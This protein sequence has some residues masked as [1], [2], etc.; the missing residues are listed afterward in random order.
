MIRYA[1]KM[2]YDG[3]DY[4]GWQ[5]QKTSDNTIQEKI[6]TAISTAIN[7]KTEIIGCGRTDS[8][9][10]S[11][12][13]VFHFDA[14]DEIDTGLLAYKLNKMLGSQM[15]ILG[16]YKMNKDFHARFDATS[17]SYIY[18][19]KKGKD[20]FDNRFA[21]E[22]MYNDDFNLKILNEAAA[23]LR[24]YDDFFTFCKT[25]TDVKTTLCKISECNWTWN[26]KTN[27]L[28]FHITADRFLR[29][30]IRL[31]VGAC[32]NVNRGKLTLSDLKKALDNKERLTMDWSV[33]AQGLMLHK[34]FYPQ[35]L[36]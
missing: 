34:I 29:G 31:V 1:C 14:V 23:L 15:T 24:L 36:E 19:I 3:T 13:Y 4:Y 25:R 30:M 22:Y 28:E 17:R 11:K 35:V 32:L 7:I 10:H 27:T 9:V 6:E 20:P 5:A 8:G 18:R 16:V 26:D 21:W 12:D 2:S 33:P